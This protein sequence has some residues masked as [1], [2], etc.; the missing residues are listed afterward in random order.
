MPSEN[1]QSCGAYML[2]GTSVGHKHKHF[3]TF[4]FL[5]AVV[6]STKL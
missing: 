5:Q 6:A 2:F 1:G 4:L 3:Q